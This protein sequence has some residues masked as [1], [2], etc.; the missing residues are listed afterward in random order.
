MTSFPVFQ[1]IEA[2]KS[3]AG[4]LGADAFAAGFSGLAPGDAVAKKNAI[5]IT[6]V[7]RAAKIPNA[8]QTFL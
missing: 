7:S 4:V 1:S 5:A 6:P 8:E 2:E 3:I